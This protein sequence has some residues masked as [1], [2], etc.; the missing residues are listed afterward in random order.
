[1]E[2]ISYD[3]E[4]KVMSRLKTRAN[5]QC[6]WRETK[7]IGIVRLLN[8]Y[9]LTSLWLLIFFMIRY[10]NFSYKGVATSSFCFCYNL[11]EIV[12]VILSSL[13]LPKI[14]EAHFSFNCCTSSLICFIFSAKAVIWE[15]KILFLLHSASFHGL[16]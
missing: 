11:Q 5:V 16:P 2:W 12:A 15:E 7:K 3:C 14:L 8:P 4:T 6:R 13:A 1:M 10:S 9:W